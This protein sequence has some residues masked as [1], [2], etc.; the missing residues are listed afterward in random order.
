MHMLKLN[1]GGNLMKLKKGKKIVELVHESQ[2]AAYL[3]AG[4]VEVKEKD[5]KSPDGSDNTGDDKK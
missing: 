1:R 5:D 3:K 2:I 4:F